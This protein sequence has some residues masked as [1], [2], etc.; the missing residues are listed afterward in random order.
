MPKVHP[1]AI[2]PLHM[3]L[4]ASFFPKQAI[5]RVDKRT[6]LQ[7]AE[8]LDAIEHRAL[9]WNELL[10]AWAVEDGQFNLKQVIQVTGPASVDVTRFYNA[11]AEAQKIV[12]LEFSI[13]VGPDIPGPRLKPLSS[14][15]LRLTERSD[16][17]SI[18]FS[19]RILSTHQERAW[20]RMMS[21]STRKKVRAFGVPV[22]T[23][24]GVGEVWVRIT[25]QALRVLTKDA[26]NTLRSIVLLWRTRRETLQ[27][28]YESQQPQLSENELEMFNDHL[29]HGWHSIVET[30][31]E[32]IKRRGRHLSP[33]RRNRA[34]ANY[35]K[36]LS[37]INND[38]YVATDRRESVFV[39]YSHKDA[40]W[41]EKLETMLAPLVRSKAVP[42]WTDR[43][44]QPGAKWRQE[45]D[46]A[47]KAA[48]V[49]VMLVSKNYLASDFIN[50]VELP[51]I[52]KSAQKHKVH[53]FCVVVGHCM[54]KA[55][56]LGELQAANDPAKP[57][58]AL[59]G[60]KQDEM[61]VEICQK[62]QQIYATVKPARG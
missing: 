37:D 12:A 51:Y 41:L 10:Y 47:M 57:L 53:P 31:F 56:P 21:D 54:Y 2:T 27:S 46:A 28:L 16:W 5:A 48:S 26:Y 42:L 62:L 25:N 11:L 38:D 8:T 19:P 24:A 52:L 44:I 49:A 39:S 9:L 4:E 58:N 61:L 34:V 40:K 45:I 7:D 20:K 1:D 13:P 15:R 18:D 36:L 43:H 6:R 23:D 17:T 59:R 29:A 50:D 14:Q 3:L 55:T 30:A 35:M 33:E 32:Y 60:P 22:A